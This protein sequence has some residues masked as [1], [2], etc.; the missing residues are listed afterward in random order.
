MWTRNADCSV[1]QL[2]VSHRCQSHCMSRSDSAQ[3]HIVTLA[4]MESAPLEPRRQVVLQSWPGSCDYMFR[5]DT[6]V[7]SQLV[8]SLA[9]LSNRCTRPWQMYK[10]PL[11]NLC[12]NWG[13]PKIGYPFSYPKRNRIPLKIFGHPQISSSLRCL[14]LLNHRL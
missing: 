11:Y 1:V 12:R 13:C 6:R 4:V 7:S 9:Q 14:V 2:L 3:S 5:R 8:K 10:M